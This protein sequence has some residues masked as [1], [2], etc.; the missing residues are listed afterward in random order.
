[1]LPITEKLMTDEDEENSGTLLLFVKG[2]CATDQIGPLAYET[3]RPCARHQRAGLGTYI[4]AK[5]MAKA[6]TF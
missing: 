5:W 1:M 3:S 4:W 6:W 2:P